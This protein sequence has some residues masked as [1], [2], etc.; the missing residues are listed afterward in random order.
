MAA[1][2][3][4]RLKRLRFTHLR[5][6]NWRNFR[7]LEADLGQR[8]FLI[9]PNAPGKSNF[10]DAFRV[11]RDIVTEGGLQKAVQRRAGGFSALRCLAAR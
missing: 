10:L 4:A 11:L 2:R 5:L 8:V 1:G 7:H 3:G 6:E 9:G